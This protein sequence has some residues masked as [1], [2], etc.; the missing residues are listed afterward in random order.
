VTYS[1]AMTNHVGCGSPGDYDADT[2][3]ASEVV[4]RM[5][6]AAFMTLPQVRIVWESDR[7]P[8]DILRRCPRT[9][10]PRAERTRSR[11]VL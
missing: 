1:G 11:S 5:A 10:T 7:I 8:H 6:N 3:V 4:D 9:C 2:R